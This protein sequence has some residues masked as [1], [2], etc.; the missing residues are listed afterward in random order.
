[1]AVC[2]EVYDI[3]ESKNYCDSFRYGEGCKFM[4]VCRVYDQLRSN[5]EEDK[6]GDFNA[7]F[8]VKRK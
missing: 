8:G 6:I 7:L 5:P 3:V 4:G 2:P 1:M